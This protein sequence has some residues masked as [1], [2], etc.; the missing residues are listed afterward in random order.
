[1]R[2]SVRPLMVALSVVLWSA[3]GAEAQWSNPAL[4]S[5]A[6]ETG[7]DI[8]G[9]K[10]AGAM[11][12]GF[13]GLYHNTGGQVR[14][15]RY[16]PGAPLGAVVT[17][18]NG[19]SYNG[20][21]SESLNGE[22][23]VVLEDWA[24]SGPNVRWYKSANGG[25]SFPSTQMLSGT[26]CAKHPHIVAYG[27]SGG[28]MLMSY[29]R[30]GTTGGCDKSLYYSRYNGTSWTADLDTGSNSHSEYDCFGMARSPMDGSVY[31][32]FD[33]DGDT[34]A[35]RR[36]ANSA[37]GSETTLF[38][39]S[40]PVRQHM[41]IN[42]SGKV[43]WVWDSNDRIKAMSYTPGLG[44]SAIEDL[45]SGGYSG[46]C[47]VCAIPGTDDFYMVV[48]RG[49]DNAHV[50]GRRWTG[51]AW[52]AEESVQNASLANAFITFPSVTA[53]VGGKIYCAW[54]YW[55][56][57]K[58]QMWYTARDSFI[59][60]GPK[61]TVTGTVRDGLGVLLPNAA[62]S[63]TGVGSAVANA[64]G[65][66]SLMATLGTHTVNASKTFYAGQ[67]V[68]GV[69][70]AENQT[71]TVNFTLTTTAP[72]PIAT[73]TVMPGNTVN[74]LSWV[75]SSSVNYNGARLRVSTT[76]YP[77]SPNAGTHLAD[78][79]GTP[80]EISSFTHSNLS[81]GTTYYYAVFAYF[82]D[83]SRYYAAGTSQSSVPFG[84]GDY[85]HDG[86]V[87]QGDFGHVQACLSGAF[88]M[89]IDPACQN[90]MFDLDNDVDETDVALWSA[91]Y[92][93]PGMPA[94][95]HCTQ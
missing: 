83:A 19:Q 45:G 54:E 88:I 65:V 52:Q 15:R 77:A 18:H 2:H 41:A 3:I 55:G 20:T 56:S 68:S 29:Y 14:Y 84:P 91:C 66:Y 95:P 69:V 58:P 57:G 37:W 23:H 89:Q 11:G 12:G 4:F 85:D 13:H 61:G 60:A 31:R 38:G 27:A 44:I 16:T 90:V 92:S 80:N 64:S 17:V 7:S 53:D 30:A 72:G 50:F 47:D 1:M 36:Y 21:I 79:G 43:M 42:A 6:S 59:P 49:G 39:G 24:G 70:V 26:N 67:A 81:N 93:G 63:I 40:W 78:I 22:I 51:G 75:G 76:G 10:L 71:T 9:P 62:V 48:A 74:Q 35:M 86:D 8:K 28:E 34:F 25:A 33:S 94:D 32:S 46:S 5:G 73:L 87:D 82:Q